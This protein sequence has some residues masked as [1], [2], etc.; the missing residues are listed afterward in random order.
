MR[1][2]VQKGL[3]AAPSAGAENACASPALAKQAS[4]P[5]R[6]LPSAPDSVL[7][8]PELLLDFY[9][10]ILDWSS[11]GMVSSHSPLR[12]CV[13]VRVMPLRRVA[14]GGVQLAI[15]LGPVLYLWDKRTG[16]VTAL[17]EFDDSLDVTAVKWNAGG[18]LLAVG[19][20]D[21]TVLIFDV[22]KG[23]QVRVMRGH[24]GRVCCLSWAEATLSSAGAS[25]V[26]HNSDVREKAHLKAALEFHNKEV[27]SLAWSP[28]RE[29]LAS[30][31]NDHFVALW[32]HR[33]GAPLP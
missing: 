9:V 8:A 21:T 5:S 22:A 16:D 7:D 10:N 27:C 13:L 15:A 25:G 30:G 1:T 19:M 32:D 33:C 20:S 2:L 12:V 6:V 28:E 23:K 29:Q 3:P 24:T 14:S 31:S 4:R 11:Q 18:N 17:H 26:V